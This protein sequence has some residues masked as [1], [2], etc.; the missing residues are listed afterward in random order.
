MLD[1]ILSRKGPRAA[2]SLFLSPSL[3]FLG[4]IGNGI[5]QWESARKEERTASSTWSFTIAWPRCDRF[6]TRVS[7]SFFHPF[8]FPFS[9]S[10][11]QISSASTVLNPFSCSIPGIRVV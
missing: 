1:Y 7:F 9:S 11:I 6:T 10:C 3:S 2:L 4:D 5:S 8:P